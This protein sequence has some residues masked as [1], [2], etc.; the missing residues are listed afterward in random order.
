MNLEFEIYAGKSYTEL[1]KEIYRRSEEKNDQIKVLIGDVRKLVKNSND[2]IILVP[3]IKNYLDVG[4]KNDEQ[5]VKLAAVLQ[6]FQSSVSG[7]GE[8]GLGITEEEKEQLLKDIESELK[9]SPPVKLPDSGS[10]PAL[11]L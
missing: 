10:I 11:N 6:R 4:V 7:D 8:G 3:L 1:I 5:L 9:S 2:A